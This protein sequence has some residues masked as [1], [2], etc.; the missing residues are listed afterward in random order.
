MEDDQWGVSERA[1][2]VRMCTHVCVSL[3]PLHS[4]AVSSPTHL[5]GPLGG[6]ELARQVRVGMA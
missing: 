4:L 2:G 1:S 6:R 5:R 3:S